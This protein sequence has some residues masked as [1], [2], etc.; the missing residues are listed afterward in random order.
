MSADMTVRAAIIG[1]SGHA[2]RIVAPAIARCRQ[3]SL[4]GVLGS[5]FARSRAFAEAN[6]APIAYSS[7]DEL[8]ADPELDAA[9]IASP[10][11]LHAEMAIACAVGGK[12][13][14]VEKPLATCVSDAQRILKAVD[15]EHVVLRVGFHHR[16][17]QAHR[18]LFK[19][20]EEDRVGSIGSFRVHRFWPYPYYKVNAT[21]S[22]ALP[23]PAEW[24]ADL[25]L[26]GGFVINDLGSHLLDILLWLGGSGGEVLDAGFTY[27]SDSA[28]VDDGAVLL[29]RLSPSD[30]LGVV[31]TSNRLASP[32]SRLEI[33]G[34]KG[35]IRAD[36]TFEG[37]G[38]ITTVEGTMS[39]PDRHPL[40]AY[41]DE[42]AEFADAI[43]G[44]PGIG[45]DGLAGFR[46]VA[47]IAAARLSD[48]A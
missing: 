44:A 3:L 48:G 21:I 9:W 1:T 10:N 17:R 40:E 4:R 7:L 41:V 19:M 38:I 11:Y 46:N 43:R 47:L 6:R 20:L 26:S 32:C 42:A 27:R 28:K 39:L 45:A 34:D 23:L 22:G 30:G 13:I 24:R 31:E 37:N 15:R 36:N 5:S 29:V 18:A 25:A 35:W 12:H 33:Y 2:A 14:L 8:V 16:F